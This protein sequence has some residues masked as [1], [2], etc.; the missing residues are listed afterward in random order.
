[1]SRASELAVLMRAMDYDDTRAAADELERLERVNAELVDVCLLFARWVQ[2][3]QDFR[4][5]PGALQQL[6]AA[7]TS[8]TKE[9]QK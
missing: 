1:M 9:Q 7:L 8:A 4:Y 5:P 3:G 2:A 6:T